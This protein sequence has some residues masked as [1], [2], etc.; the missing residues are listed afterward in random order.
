M[1]EAIDRQGLKAIAMEN[2][3]AR[4]DPD[5]MRSSLEMVRDGAA[6]IGVISHKYGQT[7]VSPEQNPAGRRL[8]ALLDD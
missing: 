6:Y 4:G 8:T 5:V 2:V 7:P 1:I 3:G